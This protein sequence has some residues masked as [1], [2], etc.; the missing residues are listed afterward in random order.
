MKTDAFILTIVLALIIAVLTGGFV[1]LIVQNNL[2]VIP[3]VERGTVASKNMIT[4]ND[5]TIKLSSGKTL[6]IL[7]NVTL[8]DCLQENQ[9]Y[10]FDCL[11]NYHTKI[12]TIQSASLDNSTSTLPLPSS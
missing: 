6:H 2:N 7:N 11:Y 4:A 5:S 10:V 1:Y 8:Y 3:S 9:K 12:T